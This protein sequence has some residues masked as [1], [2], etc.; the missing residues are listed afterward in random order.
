[1]C[2]IAGIVHCAGNPVSPVLLRRMTDTLAHRGPDGEGQYTSG[3]VGLGHRRLAV[4]DLSPAAH[5]PMATA[6]GDYVLTYNG[7]VYNF[8][9]LRLELESRGH[10]FRSRSD[11]EVVL[12]AWA[13]WGLQSVMRLN[14]MFAF[15]VH[16]RARNEVTLVR[17]R[18]GIKPLYYTIAGDTVL[19][20]SEV[21]AIIAHP[22]YRPNLDPAA[23]VEH[24]TFQN[25]LSDR[26]LLEGV[27]LLPP[28]CV[29]R[30]PC[31]A[32]ATPRPTR[33]WDYEFVEPDFADDRKLYVE[34]LDRLFTQAVGRQLVSDVAVGSYLS[35]GMDTGAITAVASRQVSEMRTFTVGF[36]MSSASGLELSCD[37]REQAERMSY[38]YGTEHYQMV[39]KAGDMERCLPQLVWHMEEPRVGQSYPNF[40]AAKLAGSFGKVVLAGTGGDELFAGYPWRYYRAV[41]N[42]SFDD[43]VRK[44]FNF[45][46][47]LLPP[48]AA[49]SF[50]RPIAGDVSGIE[51]RSMFS[52]VFNQPRHSLE[53]PDYINHSLLF[54]AKTFL[55]GLLVIE[56]KLSMAHGL[57]TRL[58]FLDNDLVDF[59]MRVPVRYKLGNL[60][61]VV[62]LNENEPGPKAEQYFARTNDGKL[63]LR[64]AMARYVPEDV[65]FAHKQGFTAPDASWFRGD[66][67]RYVQRLLLG[68]EAR[69]YDVLDRATVHQLVN[70]H[71]SGRENRRLL[72]WS[73][74]CFEQWLRLFLDGERPDTRYPT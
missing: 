56:D 63:V 37:E 24:F 18:Y 51:P 11:S 71:L 20:A 7:E 33:Y 68:K 29:L 16:D 13:E 14:G 23:V 40:Y 44:Y 22:A 43:Y 1:M 15:A 19:F 64:D 2:G 26:T 10:G 59:A 69:I 39:L 35:G 62:R 55:H 70:D 73:L 45:W 38:L 27:R 52:S 46:Q 17:D 32:G 8:Q 3:G 49:S 54:E 72:I 53:S 47:R 4:I 41:V 6:D 66:S 36:D 65:V 5:Q 67:I 30:I 48:E 74:L 57:E 34:E 58:P 60:G 42:A 9:E 21:K 31:D 50:F 61:E 25:F 12:E 28:G